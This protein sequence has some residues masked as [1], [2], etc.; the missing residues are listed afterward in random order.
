MISPGLLR[1]ARFFARA[2]CRFGFQGLWC[3]S[4]F[5]APGFLCSF[6]HFRHE[7]AEFMRLRTLRAG[8]AR[9]RAAVCLR[10]GVAVRFL[11]RRAFNAARW[12]FV[13]KC[14]ICLSLSFRATFFFLFPPAFRPGFAISVTTVLHAINHALSTARA[15][16]AG[17]AQPPPW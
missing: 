7:P 6:F 17:E 2:L 1:R 3:I 5:R 4:A 10:F 12:R 16:S 8:F 14:L 15:R 13:P 9:L 11:V